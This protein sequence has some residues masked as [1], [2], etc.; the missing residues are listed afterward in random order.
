MIPFRIRVRKSAMGSVIDMSDY[1]LDFVMP[2]MKP[3]C[4]SWRRHRR[5]SPNLRY[6]ARGRPQRRQRDCWRV[7]YFGVRLA[8]TILDVFAIREVLSWSVLGGDR[9][10]GSDALVLLRA[11]VARERHAERVEQRERLTVGLRR[12]REGDVQ[13]P[14]LIDGV[15]VDLREDD[16]L[17]D[18]HVVVAA[19][20]EGPRV[21]A[22]EVA[23]A[24]QRHRR[25]AVD[26]LVRAHVAQGDGQADRHALAQLE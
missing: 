5:Q 8:A 9:V 21:Q 10:A 3:L 18:A 6:T 26:E 16:L 1:Q 12:R 20:V 22:A 7:L 2:G 17:P 13:A 23:Q 19:A 15:I 4:A 25:Q 14:D 11:P 24:R